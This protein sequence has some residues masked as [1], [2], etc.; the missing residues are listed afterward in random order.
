MPELQSEKA[1]TSAVMMQVLLQ[2]I[3]QKTPVE[4]QMMVREHNQMT[5]VLRDMAEIMCDSPSPAAERIRQR[6]A[7][8]GQRPDMAEIPGYDAISTDHKELS[9]GLVRSLDDLDE[10][11]RGGDETAQKALLRLREHLGPR[12]L[13]E[14][15]TYIVGAGMAGR[16]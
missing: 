12:T 10:L 16:G 11:I 8:L 2:C 1:Q 6:A 3:A 14:F 5:A 15:G 9:T 7:D 4:Q 13:Q